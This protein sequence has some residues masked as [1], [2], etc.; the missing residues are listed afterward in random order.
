MVK[1]S[2]GD[3]SLLVSMYSYDM[4]VDL[5]WSCHDQDQTC[6]YCS[7]FWALLSNQPAKWLYMAV[8]TYMVKKI[9]LRA[10]FLF[11]MALYAMMTD[12]KHSCHD[13]GYLRLHS[14]KVYHYETAG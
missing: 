13:Q 2:K 4:Q 8:Q 9:F 1:I 11:H 7:P 6:L 14:S 12:I 10:V 3:Q 5:K